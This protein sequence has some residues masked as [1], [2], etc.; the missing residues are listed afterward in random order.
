MYYK[1]DE[2]FY[3][4]FIIINMFF[5]GIYLFILVILFALENNNTIET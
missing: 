4:L 3:K 2:T 5:T 1:T